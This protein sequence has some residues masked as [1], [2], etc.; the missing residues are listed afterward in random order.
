MTTSGQSL[1]PTLSQTPHIVTSSAQ[2]ATPTLSQTVHSDQP[3]NTS[4]Q[5]VT[6]TLSQTPHIVAVEAAATSAESTT[7]L[8][9][10]SVAASAMLVTSI[11]QQPVSSTETMCPSLT[12]SDVLMASAASSVSV[13]GVTDTQQTLSDV[14]EPAPS[15]QT[16]T[17]NAHLI[18]NIALQ[19]VKDAHLTLNTNI[20]S[21]ATDSGVLSEQT[22]T[23]V[24]V[25]TKVTV[26]S[27]DTNETQQM[28]SQHSTVD[29]LNVAEGE[30]I[31]VSK[32]EPMTAAVSSSS[33]LSVSEDSCGVKSELLHKDSV[34]DGVSEE[35]RQESATVDEN[36][37]DDVHQE[38]RAVEASNTDDKNTGDDDAGDKST[39][40]MRDD[41]DG[42]TET[43]R[44]QQCRQVMTLPADLLSHIN[45]SLPI[46][47]SHQQHHLT[48]PAT[49]VYQSSSGLRL[50]LPPDSL[51]DEYVNNKQ[52]AFTLGRSDDVGQSQV[53]NVSL[54]VHSQ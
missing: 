32:Q 44:E 24:M 25:N 13:T 28:S 7:G 31:S 52:L 40:V 53:I 10:G 16:S 18:E 11:D 47:L 5:P 42:D 14:V 26:T 43:V 54:T 19:Q 8:M 22:D 15:P 2:S 35:T 48:V 12:T 17:D 49:N 4:D 9:S 6:P 46:T 30:K 27:V 45:I 41:A 34:G 3:V 50:L 37:K 51:P 36:D 1:T 33:K 23:G 39:G 20:M 21:S 29:D 38:K